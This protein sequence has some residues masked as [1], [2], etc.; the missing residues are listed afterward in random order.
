MSSWLMA[1]PNEFVADAVCQQLLEA[2]VHPLPLGASARLGT[3]AGRRDI[4]VA[5]GDLERARQILK[6]IEAVSDQ[7]LA[8]LSEAAQP[9]QR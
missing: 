8:K 5:D 7:E 1:A 9:E 3:L 6:E 4:Y 2:G